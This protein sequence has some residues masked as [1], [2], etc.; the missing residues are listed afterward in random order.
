MG[1]K[2]FFVILL[3]SLFFVSCLQTPGLIFRDGKT[4]EK[5]EVERP[6][7]VELPKVQLETR[8]ARKPFRPSFALVLGPGL[9]RTFAHIGLLKEFSRAEIPVTA[10]VG[11]GWS[12]LSAFEFLNQGSVNGLEWKASR[13]EELK[14][15]A[16]IN[17]WSS[18]LKA[19]PLQEAARLSQNLLTEKKGSTK[20]GDF[21]CPL[22]SAKRKRLVLAKQDGLDYCL[23]LPPLFDSGRTYSPYVEDLE[24]VAQALR[25]KGISKI[26]FISVLGQGSYWGKEESKVDNA[27]YWKWNF[28]TYQ[29]QEAKKYF[30]KTFAIESET[31]L[32]D[33]TNILN[34]VRLGES[35]GR[36][37]VQFLRENYQY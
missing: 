13:S 29:S 20:K 21:Y 26:I 34:D 12:S 6:S 33:F 31:G 1:I 10:I 37:L 2:N 22:Y 16:A 5:T 17:F 9:S 4:G 24:G 28:T 23:A 8:D 35:T 7:N 14:T 19:K 15:L 3:C 36:D 27:S 25:D 11:T 32:L 18:S 30:D